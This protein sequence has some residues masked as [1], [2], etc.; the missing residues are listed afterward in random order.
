MT[1]RAATPSADVMT[2]MVKIG[3]LPFLS[4]VSIF[5]VRNWRKI[6]DNLNNDD[7][8]AQGLLSPELIELIMGIVM[9][10]FQDC[11]ANASHSAWNRMQT[12][13]SSKEMERVSDNVRLNFFIKRA[14][15]DLGIPRESGDVVAIRRAL[16]TVAAGTSKEDFQTAQA[17]ALFLTI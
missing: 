8:V 3:G 16:V 11:F 4:K 7:A 9:G 12:Y 2:R 14:L 6:P 5:A 1:E 10:L 13:L 17:E 15:H